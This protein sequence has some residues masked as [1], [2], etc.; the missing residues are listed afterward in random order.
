MTYEYR[1]KEC[2]HKF[3]VEVVGRLTIEKKRPLSP[4]CPKCGK[5][6]AIKLI[7]APNLKFVGSAKGGGLE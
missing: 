4:K 6:G 7:S 2:R 3:E 1:C 5:K